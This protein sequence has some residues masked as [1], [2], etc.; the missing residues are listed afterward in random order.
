MITREADYAIRV[1]LCLAAQPKGRH[2]SAAEISETMFLPYRFARKIIGSLRGAGLVGAS[3]GKNGGVY[4]LK[5][6]G[7]ISVYDILDIFDPKSLLF[8]RCHMEKSFC[9]RKRSC[10]V[11]SKME[12]VQERL[13]AT[14]RKISLAD[15]SDIR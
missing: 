7:K 15:I 9:Q 6:P 5:A 14:L 3:R 11:H 2:V 8:N 4:L 10:R 1:A 12:S 13:N